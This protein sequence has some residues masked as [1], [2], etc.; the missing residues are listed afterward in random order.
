MQ[1]LAKLM[2]HPEIRLVTRLGSPPWLLLGS[3]TIFQI[4]R[5]LSHV[6]TTKYSG[7]KFS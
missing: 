3:F 2:Y 4:G 5:Y 6:C 7:Y 1:P